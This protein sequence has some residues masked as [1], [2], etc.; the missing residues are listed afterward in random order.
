MSAPEATPINRT[1]T[2]RS[3]SG[4]PGLFVPSHRSSSGARAI[5]HINDLGLP[6][7]RYVRSDVSSLMVGL[8]LM[9][10]NRWA[11]REPVNGKDVLLMRKA[12]EARVGLVG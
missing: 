1:H 8:E 3:F 5:Y 12:M 10:H 11:V 2:S 7:L 9:R 4:N 6:H